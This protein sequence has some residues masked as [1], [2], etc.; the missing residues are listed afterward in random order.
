MSK[1]SHANLGQEIF[2]AILIPKRE[3]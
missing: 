2:S 3:P 1:L